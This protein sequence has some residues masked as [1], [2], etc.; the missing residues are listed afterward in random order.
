MFNRNKVEG[1][2]IEEEEVVRAAQGEWARVWEFKDKG[3]GTARQRAG[4]DDGRAQGSRS[5]ERQSDKAKVTARTANQQLTRL[6]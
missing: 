1:K 4:D 6:N 3:S 2:G 5:A